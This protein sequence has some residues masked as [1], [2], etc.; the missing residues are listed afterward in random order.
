MKNNKLLV[1]ILM[2]FVFTQALY[3]QDNIAV[4]ENVGIDVFATDIATTEKTPNAF[5][6]AMQ[7]VWG[8]MEGRSKVGVNVA[9]S[10]VMN[11]LVLIGDGVVQRDSV[12]S[13]IIGV[14][15]GDPDLVVA[16]FNLKT[17]G[18]TWGLSLYYDFTIFDYMVVSIEAGFSTANVSLEQVEYNTYSDG[19]TDKTLSDYN[20][21]YR[22][23]P[24]SFGV[25]FFPWKKAPYGFYVMPKI[26]GTY[27]EMVGRVDI[28][29]DSND[30]E[31]G[32]LIAYTSGSGVYM[33]VEL[34]WN[35]ELFPNKGK[36][37]P[38]HMGIDIGFIDLGYYVVPWATGTINNL[39]NAGFISES[40]SKY[41]WASNIR[42]LVLPKIGFSIRF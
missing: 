34:G 39:D 3:S 23:L 22:A 38:V 17:K 42:A 10:V 2:L 40:I 14:L 18:A 35:I 13:S 8:Y 28:S 6:S 33:S 1:S 16:D 31:L 26:G 15:G 41:L 12:A 25:K 30:D 24:Y 11:S 4:S 37:W 7:N 36:D 21:S 29:A 32:M 5:I 19:S 20:L 9:Q 27:I